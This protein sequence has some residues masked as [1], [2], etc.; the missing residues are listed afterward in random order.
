[1]KKLH[2]LLMVSLI[3]MI[4]SPSLIFAQDD[5]K[6]NEFNPVNTGVTT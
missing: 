2:I 4:I 3:M 5:I 6:D 1:M